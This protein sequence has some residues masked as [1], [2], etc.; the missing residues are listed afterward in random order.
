MT[1]KEMQD[2]VLTQAEF[3]AL[4]DY[5]C[6]IPSGTTIGKQWKRRRNYHD[7]S[8]GWLRGEYAESTRPGRVLI[9]WRNIVVE[10]EV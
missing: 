7:E 5:S 1:G 10:G 4:P 2:V 8:S 9:N 6:S 3:D